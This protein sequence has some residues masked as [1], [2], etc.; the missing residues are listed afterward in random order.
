MWFWQ[1]AMSSLGENTTRAMFAEYLIATA[2]GCA[3]DGPRVESEPADLRYQDHLVE[4]SSSADHQ[5][6]KQD[7]P[8]AIRFD[9]A[10][11]RWRNAEAD[12]PGEE[13]SRPADVYVFCHFKGEAMWKEVIEPENWFF[14]VVATKTL[15]EE[16]GD[17]KTI[18][19]RRLHSLTTATSHENVHA[20]VDKTLNRYAHP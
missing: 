19:L 18:G 6:W 10:A 13:L 5:S 9:V 2:L 3:D 16:L 4:V 14:Y 1:W 11:R 12:E 17:Q 7:K 15:D 20:A 8:S